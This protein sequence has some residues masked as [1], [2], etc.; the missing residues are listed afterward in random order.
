MDKR[1]SRSWLLVR[2]RKATQAAIEEHNQKWGRMLATVL[3]GYAREL[4]EAFGETPK[5]QERTKLLKAKRTVKASQI[6]REALSF[7]RYMKEYPEEGLEEIAAE[8]AIRETH[9]SP[10]FSIK[11]YNEAVR[12]IQE[13][14]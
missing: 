11:A 5:G 4:R 13:N 3:E 10:A 7:V 6:S 8:W 9:G 2:L 14:K 1:P 12:F